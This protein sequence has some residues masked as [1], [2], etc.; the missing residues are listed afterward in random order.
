VLFLMITAQSFARYAPMQLR[1]Y[2][3]LYNLQQEHR[4]PPADYQLLGCDIRCVLD[5]PH[6]SSG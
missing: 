3:K 1:I 5:R 2:M 4:L 6:D